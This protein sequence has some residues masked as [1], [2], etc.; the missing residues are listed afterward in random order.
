VLRCARRS[1]NSGDKR[2]EKDLVGVSFIVE[3]LL[4]RSA[5]LSSIQLS[6]ATTTY[7]LTASGSRLCRLLDMSSGSS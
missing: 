7:C 6:C 5:L 3:L 2:D 1:P 4:R